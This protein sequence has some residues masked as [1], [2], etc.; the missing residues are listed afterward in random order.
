[1]K[2]YLIAGIH[3]KHPYLQANPS[4]LRYVTHHQ[5]DGAITTYY[6]SYVDIRYTRFTNGWS[7]QTIYDCVRN[8][9]TS[10]FSRGK[11]GHF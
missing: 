3:N 8:Y 7:K 1:M 4:S 11:I 9:T 5:L 2:N 10:T 6:D